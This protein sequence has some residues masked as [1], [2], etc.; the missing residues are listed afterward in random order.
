MT[1][2]STTVPQSLTVAQHLLRRCVAGP[3]APIASRFLRSSALS[4]VLGAHAFSSSS[5]QSTP[6]HTREVQQVLLSR[7]QAEGVGARVRRSIGRPELKS[8]DPFLML[9]GQWMQ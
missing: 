4:F 5:S 3:A 1:V 7:E 8:F 9:D 6:F 2:S